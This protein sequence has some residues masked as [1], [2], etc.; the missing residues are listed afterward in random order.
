[1]TEKYLP[2]F[3]EE[4]RGYCQMLAEFTG[5]LHTPLAAEELGSAAAGLSRLFHTI[6]GLSSSLEITDVAGLAEGLESCLLSISAN[7]ADAASASISSPLADLLDF[8]T[9]YL[10]HRL[11]A[12]EMSGQ[13]QPPTP[14]DEE[15]LRLLE[16]RLWDLGNQLEPPEEGAMPPAEALS[17]DDLAILRAFNES[18][19]S[20]TGEATPHT[21]HPLAPLP[22]TSPA[23][24]NALADDA[25]PPGL[26]ELFHA[27]TKDDLTLLQSALARLEWPEE[28]PAAAQE[29]RHIAHK[30]KGAASTLNLQVVAG[31]SHCLEDILDLLKSRRLEYAP[32][33]VDALM[34]GALE[35]EAALNRPAASEENTEGLERLRAEYEAL[36]AVS[37]PEN[38][39][40]PGATQPPSPHLAAALQQYATLAETALEQSNPSP[41]PPHGPAGGVIGRELSLRVEVSRLDQLMGLAGELASNRASTEQV[42]QEINDALAEVR[43][44]VQKMTQLV[45]Q[46]DEEPTPAPTPAF[47]L[48]QSQ[49]EAT[50]LVS[51]GADIHRATTEELELEDL[52]NEHSHL[53]R[54]LRE[55]V[56]DI[57]TVSDNL[58]NLLLQMNGLAE[59]QDKLTSDIQHDITHLRLVPIGQIFPRL[60]LTARRIAQEQNKQINF[61]PTGAATEIDRDIIEAITGPLVQLVSNCVV[62]GIE[63]VEERR[64]HGKPDV[65]TITLHAY[66]TGNEISIE[67]GDDGRGIAPQRLIET[68]IAQGKLSPEEA[69][70][71]DLEQ[72]LNLILLP[73][74]STSPEVTTV[75]GRGVG[76]NMVQTIVESLKGTLHIHSTPGEGTTFHLHLPISL[77]ILHALFVRVGEQTYA[78]PM[79]SVARIWQPD[80]R[81]DLGD[82]LF[83]SLGKVLSLAPGQAASEAANA[84]ALKAALIVPLRQR[85][86]GVYVDEVLTDREVVIKRLPPHLRRRGVRGAILNPTGELLLLLDLPEL[87]HRALREALA[88]RSPS[89]AAPAPAPTTTGPK[90]LVVDDSL[91]M[92]RTLE[93][94]LT[95]AGYQ[96]TSAKDGLEA[97]RL[98]TQDRPQVVLLD[99]EMPQLDGYGLLGLMRGQ[100]RF[101]T[102][103]VAILTSRAAD[104]FRQHAMDL[105]AN[106]YLVKPCPHDVLLQTVA[107][108][109]NQASPIGK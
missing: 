82:T 38:L 17:D 41:E 64:A 79:S 60:Q 70:H 92:R 29:M 47:A 107:E 105:G 106:A 5:I 101:S 51:L 48:S 85:Q 3:V 97:M 83:F 44:A 99:I 46:L 40:D 87:A 19:L 37:E 28:R 102:T 8:T 68:A 55:G 65:G 77:G 30:I 100:P 27:E 14:E 69:E 43:R 63:S 36:L 13:F 11:Q 18:D 12:M 71:L 42:R 84:L 80:D 78:V 89:I 88:E 6:A 24:D 66:Y 52:N 59:A 45:N 75:A 74:I 33:V 81:Q 9:A 58:H 62:H 109:A 22:A 26:I 16:E 49:A 93:L 54:A 67:V 23:D 25:I 86:I 57:S 50:R 10:S 35:I 94:Q 73:D 95:R 61:L 2:T 90:V 34:R 31:L 39:D 1:M 7:P 108:L 32:V 15:P 21:T 4:M 98:M 96:V 76:M 56:N 104:K 72:A 103:Q 91:F 53:R 20:A